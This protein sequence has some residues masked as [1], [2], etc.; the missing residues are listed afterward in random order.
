MIKGR[1]T[2]KCV[3]GSSPHGK[4]NK[5]LG[6]FFLCFFDSSASVSKITR[7]LQQLWGGKRKY[8]WR[9]ALRRVACLHSFLLCI[10]NLP[11]P[12][13]LARAS[14]GNCVI[15][16]EK[17]SL[18]HGMLSNIHKHKCTF[19][20]YSRHLKHPCVPLPD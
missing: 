18:T 11:R 1:D 17:M 8:P 20:P 10:V 7:N 19:F 2:G 15:H 4:K 6:S 13:L 3:G 5:L 9:N 14:G 12:S 16:E